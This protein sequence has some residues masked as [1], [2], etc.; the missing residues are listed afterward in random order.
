[1]ICPRGIPRSPRVKE[2]LPRIVVIFNFQLEGQPHHPALIQVI[3]PEGDRSPKTTSETGQFVTSVAW[4]TTYA[5]TPSP[6]V[7]PEDTLGEGNDEVIL[8]F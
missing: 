4:R 3:P 8:E 7:R 1:M 2:T 5:H 6:A